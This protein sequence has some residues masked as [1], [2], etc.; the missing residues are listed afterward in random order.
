[1]R[2]AKGGS[3][4]RKVLVNP[5]GGVRAPSGGKGLK[6]TVSSVKGVLEAQRGSEGCKAVARSARVRRGGGERKRLY[7]DRKGSVE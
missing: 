2:D 3:K 4:N 7:K 1:M 6:G 5:P